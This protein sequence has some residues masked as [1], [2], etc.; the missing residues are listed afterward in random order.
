MQNL[1]AFYD[2]TGRIVMRSTVT[3]RP[4]FTMEYLISQAAEGFP[5]G[6]QAVEVDSEHSAATHYIDVT[7][8]QSVAY[9]PQPSKDHTFDYASGEWV[10]TRTLA[11]LKAQLLV[12]AT[13]KRWEV[14]NGGLTLPNGVSV[15]T[16][17][18]DQDR[19]TSVIVNAEIAGITS[20]DFKAASGW[21]TLQIA[22]LRNVAQAIAFH[23]QACFTAERLHHEAIS[24]LETEISARNYD[25]SANW[26]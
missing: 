1:F 2:Q 5:P 4:P 6:L 23:V 24:A 9:P 21:V 18:A 19:I 13:A 22:D 8:Q 17:K 10:D 15:L 12:L 26:P 16:G 7:T 25:I 14:E 20:V 3:P 11:Q